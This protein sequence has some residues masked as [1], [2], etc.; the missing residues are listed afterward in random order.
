MG[1]DAVEKRARQILDSTSQK[2]SHR[3]CFLLRVKPERL[4]EYLDV[5]QAVWAEMRQ[6][7]TEAGWR[8]YSLF[9]QVET[10]MV[11]G[12]YEAEDVAEA[13]RAM[14]AKEVNTRWQAEMAQYF[15]QPN[16]GTNEVLPQYFYLP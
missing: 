4:D 7:L 15:V 3:R 12:Y 16:G 9:V 10:G 1:K 11:V 6:A 14:A 13:D 2:S 5:H 8:N